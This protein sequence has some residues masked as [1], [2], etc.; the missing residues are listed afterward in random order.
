MQLKCR[1]MPCGFNTL[2]GRGATACGNVLRNFPRSKGFPWLAGWSGSDTLPACG[3]F[4]LPLFW[5]RHA[6]IRRAVVIGAHKSGA[7]LALQSELASFFA[8]RKIASNM[9]AVSFP[10][11]VFWFDGW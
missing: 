7:P 5:Q 11:A 1:R 8:S 9:T 3:S 2:A 4:N 10:V 6:D